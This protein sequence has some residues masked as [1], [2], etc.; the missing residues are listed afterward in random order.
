MVVAVV[1]AVVLAVVLASIGV[2]DA[3]ALRAAPPPDGRLGLVASRWFPSGGWTTR[4]RLAWLFTALVVV[5]AALIAVSTLIAPSAHTPAIV[6]GAAL[7]ALLGWTIFWRP[8]LTVTP[9]GLVVVNPWRTHRVGWGELVD[10]QTRF[11]L[12]LVTAGRRIE[13]FAAPGPSGL[14]A[15]RGRPDPAAGAGRRIEEP[16]LGDWNARPSDSS[17]T[18]SGV[19]ARVVRGHWQDL[20]EGRVETPPAA[21]RPSGAPDPTGSEAPDHTGSGPHTR[22][23]L[24]AAALA[25][26]AALA[27]LLA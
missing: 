17:S 8:R 2:A 18:D 26:A 25:T 7:A 13:V 21:A 9:A 27:W 16:S 20:V 22:T 15:L 19:A 14:T 4:P 1:V 23:A 12:T 6:L 5:P 24:L 3:L 11:M 10:V